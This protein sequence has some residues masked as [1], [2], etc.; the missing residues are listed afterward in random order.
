MIYKGNEHLRSNIDL[1]LAMKVQRTVSVAVKIVCYNPRAFINAKGPNE[2]LF[3]TRFKQKPME[4]LEQIRQVVEHLYF[5]SARF[6][7]RNPEILYQNQ[8]ISIDYTR[9]LDPLCCSA[10]TR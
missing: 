10:A 3:L 4:E 2:I 8:E 5:D 9:C 7:M 1:R 6:I